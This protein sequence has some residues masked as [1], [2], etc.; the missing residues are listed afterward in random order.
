M[1]RR[2]LPRNSK[3]DTWIIAHYE[4]CTI[5]DDVHDTDL[6]PHLRTRT[7]PPFI[8][9]VVMGSVAVFLQ[10][11]PS[12]ECLVDQGIVFTRVRRE[13]ELYVNL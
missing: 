5:E 11:E 12:P 7:R 2:A 8:I 3:S 9:V 13:R 1:T 10:K 4:H 6:V